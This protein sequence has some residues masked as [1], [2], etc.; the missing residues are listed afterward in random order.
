MA[1][2]QGRHES[3]EKGADVSLVPIYLKSVGNA[4]YRFVTYL[5]S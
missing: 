1:P 2:E 3:R 4:A 5:G